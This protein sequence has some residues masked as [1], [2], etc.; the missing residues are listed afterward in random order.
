MLPENKDLIV[1]KALLLFNLSEKILSHSS[2]KIIL[3]IL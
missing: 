1:S 2:I 3:L